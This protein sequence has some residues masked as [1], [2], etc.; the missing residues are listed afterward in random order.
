MTAAR[1]PCISG[2]EE[3]YRLISWDAVVVST[4]SIYA[5]V[6][7]DWTALV[8]RVSAHQAVSQSLG[9]WVSIPRTKTENPAQDLIVEEERPSVEGTPEP[10]LQPQQRKDVLE[11]LRCVNPPYR[12]QDDSVS[13]EAAMSNPARRPEKVVR[14]Q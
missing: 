14:G 8:K 5:S 9:W 7:R 2:G 11:I 1:S 3:E 10:W 6:P 12:S 13:G 4:T